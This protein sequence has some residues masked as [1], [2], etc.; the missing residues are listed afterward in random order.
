M[1]GRRV[2]K[3]VMVENG[4][5]VIIFLIIQIEKNKACIIRR[6]GNR[7]RHSLHRNCFQKHVVE[8]KIEGRMEVTGG[9]GRRRKQLLDDLKEKRRFWKLKEEALGRTLWRIRFGRGYGPV[10]KTDYRMNDI[11]MSVGRGPYYFFM[12]FRN[13]TCESLT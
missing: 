13:H 6:K 3:G 9:R 10:V 11:R 1:V 4:D 7:V 2:R 8:V 12:L 5:R